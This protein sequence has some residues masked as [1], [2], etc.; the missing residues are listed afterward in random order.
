[1]GPIVEVKG[2]EEVALTLFADDRVKHK[3][4]KSA[5]PFPKASRINVT[6]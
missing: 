4:E 5:V 3:R 6:I 2:S 1:L